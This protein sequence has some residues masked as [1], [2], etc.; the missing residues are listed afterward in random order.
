MDEETLLVCLELSKHLLII[1]GNEVRQVCLG[2][3]GGC[4]DNMSSPFSTWYIRQE[5]GAGFSGRK[6]THLGLQRLNDSGFAPF[7][8]GLWCRI[9]LRVVFNWSSDG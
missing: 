3:G 1:S 8:V 9:Q 2:E 4:C 7:M 6:W 5:C